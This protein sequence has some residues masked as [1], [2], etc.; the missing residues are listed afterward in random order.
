MTTQVAKYAA[1][2]AKME[3]RAKE[4]T[5]PVVVEEFLRLADNWRH[6]EWKSKVKRVPK[7]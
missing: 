5:H 7:T 6:L 1:K 4:A 2:A 3:Q